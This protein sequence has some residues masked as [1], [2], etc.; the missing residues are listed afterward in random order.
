VEINMYVILTLLNYLIYLIPLWKS[1]VV[2][3]LTI[4]HFGKKD[5]LNWEVIAY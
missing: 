2:K 3:S 1:Q 4:F 5:Q